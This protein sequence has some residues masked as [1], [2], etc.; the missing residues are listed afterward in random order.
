[1]YNC[2]MRILLKIF[3]LQNLLLIT[4][5]LFGQNKIHKCGTVF[6]FGLEQRRAAMQVPLPTDQCAQINKVNKTFQISM[7]IAVNSLGIQNV[8]QAEIDEAM[9]K[10][11]NDFRPCGFQFQVCTT[12]IMEDDRFDS[13]TVTTAYNEEVQ[14]TS[15]YYE[16]NT[17]NVYL[18]D[19]VQT[20][21]GG[22][23]G[24]AYF[25]G[26]IDIIVI[27][28]FNMNDYSDV[29]SHEMG[30]FFGLYHTFET[31]FG[32]E[33]ADGTNCEVTGDLVCDT[34]ADPDEDGNAIDEDL[35]NYSGPITQDSNGDWYVP[36]TDN[37]MSYYQHECTCR[38]TTGQYN[39]MV[40]QYLTLRNY[41]W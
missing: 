28:K 7:H 33:L 40:D 29:F 10:L 26:G 31:E 13:L 15:I 24:Y 18:V 12:Q 1:M 22:V 38:F 16:P 4:A 8:D 35:C 41:L 30:H 36:P 9:E 3:F 34:N 27:D 14:M 23:Q 21:E 39:R 5:V 25:P 6:P 2:V 37:F 17:I 32:N 11:N 20:V 19:T